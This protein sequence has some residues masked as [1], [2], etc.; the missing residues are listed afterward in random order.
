MK[1]GAEPVSDYSVTCRTLAFDLLKK[2]YSEEI[3]RKTGID[4]NL[5]PKAVLSGTAIGSVDKRLGS[6]LGI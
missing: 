5:F 1:L 3:L 6:S 4:I 2:Q